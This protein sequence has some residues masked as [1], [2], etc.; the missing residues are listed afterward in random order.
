MNLKRVLLVALV[1]ALGVHS[2]SLSYRLEEEQNL[3][4]HDLNVIGFEIHDLQLQTQQLQ[5]DLDSIEFV[6]TEKVRLTNY[7]PNDELGSGF[8]TASTLS[9]DDF[10]VNSKGWYTYQGKLVLGAAIYRYN[11]EA[12]PVGYKAYDLFDEID[13]IIEGTSYSAIILDICGASYW[14][15]DFQRYDLF[16]KDK[17]SGVDTLALIY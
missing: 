7:Y 14:N 3:L 13:V 9:V 4:Q 17:N 6:N 11:L 5:A 16:V 12:L 1:G 8:T 15:E 2:V 10:E